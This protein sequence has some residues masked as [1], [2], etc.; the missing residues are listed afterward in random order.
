M[1]RPRTLLPALCVALVATLAPPSVVAAQTGVPP[2]SGQS[3]QLPGAR[4][5][6]GVIDRVLVRV[7]D[8]TILHSDFEA[9]WQDQL[10][11]VAAQLPQEQIEAQ[12]PMLRL[13]MMRA[14][15]EEAMLEMHAEQLGITADA[16]EVDRAI[17]NMREQYGLQD[18]NQWQQALAQAGLS[19]ALLREQ[20]AGSIVQ[21]RMLQQE[22]MRQVFVSQREIATYYE[23]NVDQFSQPPQ[24]L[25][26]QIILVYQGADRAAVRERA[27]SALA[28][29]RAGISLTAVG[30]KY[31][32]SGDLVQDAASAGWLSPDDIQPEVREVI[33]SITPLEY[34]EII[35]GRFGY[36]IIQLMDRKDGETATLDQ[37][38]PQ[39]RQLL[40]ERKMEERLGEYTNELM[41][42]VSLEIYAEEFTDLPQFWAEESQGAPNG[43]SRQPRQ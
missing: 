21:Q 37:I 14:L 16:N 20:A 4:A 17:A 43:T 8:R 24:V 9:Q 38:G 35:E 33:E 3:Q 18:D 6:G 1:L 15:V 26:Q 19:E 30:N 32:Q 25:F 28:E 10:N 29:L 39:I 27:E 7:G 41:Q 5:A 36:H 34:S 22:I 31:A 13:A 12:T 23:D 11:A 40:T 42:G 2:A